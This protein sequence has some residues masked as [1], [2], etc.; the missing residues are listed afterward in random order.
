[1]Y[2]ETEQ[3]KNREIIKLF[4]SRV[5]KFYHLVPAPCLI[6]FLILQLKKYARAGVGTIH[7]W[8]IICRHVVIQ[9]YALDE[10]RN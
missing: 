5:I 7:T 10:E 1:M 3:V 8:V 4:A 9:R 2:S 6:E